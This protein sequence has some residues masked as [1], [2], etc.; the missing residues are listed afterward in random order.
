MNE[1]IN[2]C[3]NKEENPDNSCKNVSI[4]FILDIFTYK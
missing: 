2:I 3:E 4:K 1:E